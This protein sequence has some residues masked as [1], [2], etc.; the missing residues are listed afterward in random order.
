MSN[1]IK[2]KKRKNCPLCNA[3]NSEIRVLLHENWELAE[4]SQCSFVYMPVVPVYEMMKEEF[5]WEK[6][7]IPSKDIKLSKKIRRSIKGLIKRNK[8]LFLLDKYIKEGQVLDI[9][10]GSG[11]KFDD[12]P[13]KFIPFGIDISEKSAFEA[14]TNFEKR[15]GTAICA[16]ATDVLKE[17][18]KNKFKGAILRSYLEHEHHPFEVLDE[19]KETLTSDGSIII[20]VPNYASVNRS[21]RGKNWCGYRFPDHVNQFTPFTLT[22]MVKKAGYKIIK[23]NYLDKQITSDNMWMVA[24]PI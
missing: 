20:K 10:C 24:Q 17:Y 5:A 23:F 22:K 4:C 12:I 14:K 15:G 7:F 9:G 1:N 6:N 18:G 21:V 11:I 3:E 19:L 8:L 2:I 13:Q 16:P